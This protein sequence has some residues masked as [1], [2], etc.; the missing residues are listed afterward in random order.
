MIKHFTLLALLCISYISKADGL[1][2][3]FISG[4]F[5]EKKQNDVY[6]SSFLEE[7]IENSESHKINRDMIP[8]DWLPS[9]VEKLLPTVVNIS[10]QQKQEIVDSDSSYYH[11]PGGDIL[12]EFREFFE[13][14]DPFGQLERNSK[15]SFNLGSGAIIHPS[16]IILTS[17]HLIGN[18]DSIKVTT[19]DGQK[20]QAE[21][22]GMDTE[23]DVAVLKINSDK[24]LPYASLAPDIDNLKIG[25]KTIAIGN[26]LGLCSSVTS[27]VVSATNRVI[28]SSRVDFIQTDAAINKGSSGGPLF[29]QYGE[30]IGTNTAIYTSSGGNI[31]IGFATPISI[32]KPVIESIVHNGKF[33]YGWI[34]IAMQQITEEIGQSLGLDTSEGVIISQIVK[35]S[36]AEA[37]GLMVGDVV[38]KIDKNVIKTTR[39]FQK[40]IYKTDIGQSI[41]L[42]L[43]RKGQVKSIPIK[44]QK[45][46]SEISESDKLSVYK[47]SGIS[48][49]NLSEKNRAKFQISNDIKGVLISQVKDFSFL[50]PGDVILSVAN[51]D[52][53]DISKFISVIEKEKENSS[54]SVLLFVRREDFNFFTALPLNKE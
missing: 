10:I 16:G 14:S 49:T 21:L 2:G 52:V 20:F 9:V 5:S 45:K 3:D 19:L 4:I 36:P 18:Y 41:T 25:Q 33:E 43:L 23:T 47:I 35:G 34:G 48:V 37:A 1:V 42:E 54:K 12:R 6:S 26:P 44:I 24:D 30:I 28:N 40:Y 32:T 31:G 11:F 53:S 46:T 27:G 15:P 17:A 29:N 22:M 8:E 7:N 50:R 13:K 38:T 39:E 51:T